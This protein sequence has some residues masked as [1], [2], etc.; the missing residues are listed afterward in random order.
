MFPARACSEAIATAAA[1]EKAVPKEGAEGSGGAVA[2]ITTAYPAEP[3]SRTEEVAVFRREI[4]L[5][6]A[7]GAVK[8]EVLRASLSREFGPSLRS[9]RRCRG[10]PGGAVSGRSCAP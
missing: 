2:A 3:S 5:G 8:G 10:C 9:L 4:G 1:K 7:A 6:R